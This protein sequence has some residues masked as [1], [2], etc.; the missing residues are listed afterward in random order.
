MK[1]DIDKRKNNNKQK[2]SLAGLVLIFS[3]LATILT[4]VLSYFILR[5]STKKNVLNAKQ[6]LAVEIKED[7][8]HTIKQFPTYE[9]L[10]TYW[11]QNKDT[12]EV[13]YYDSEVTLQKARD[14]AA[15]TGLATDYVTMED[16]AALSEEDCRLYAEIIYN[17]TLQLINLLKNNYQSAYLSIT[18]ASPDYS[19]QTFIISGAS[20]GQNRGSGM[21][22]AFVIGVI[23]DTTK[24]QKKGLQDAV[25]GK[26]SM[27]K[28]GHYLDAYGYVLDIMDGYHVVVDVVYDTS[29]LTRET[30]SQVLSDMFLFVLLQGSLALF[31]YILTYFQSVRP[32]NRIQR[33]VNNYRKNKDSEKVLKS[34][35]KIHLKNEL[36]SLSENI[37]EMIV[38]IDQYLEDIQ[39]ITSEKEKIA[40]ELSVATQIQA[41]MLPSTFPAFPDRKEFDLYATMTPAKDVG[42]DFY[43]FFLVD[44]DHIGLVIA[45]VSGKGIPA[46]LFMVN[47]KTR[48]QNQA[49]LGKSPAEIL[50][51]VN[52]QICAINKS[53]FFVT[54]WI[55]IIDLTTGK[56]L[57]ANAGHEHPVIRHKD[58]SY[59]LVKYKHS[60][61]VGALDSTQ[62][63]EHEFLLKPGDSIF[64][65]TDGVPEATN[66]NKEQ[67]SIGRMLNSLNSHSKDSLRELLPN[68][69]KDIDDFAGD[70]VQ[71]DDITM[72]GFDYYGP[73]G[74]EE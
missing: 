23:M 41:E 45:D 26:N 66:T 53:G 22:D 10:I 18:V 67:F 48:I 74:K 31:L 62:Y 8:V 40:A 7:I 47:S 38:S 2:Y 58:G 44:D 1:K 61:M 64:V 56:G 52:E 39:T 42:G 5:N 21:D 49:M 60:L 27:I 20:P 59:E 69:K 73:A 13:E 71:F 51:A 17:Q 24:E 43:D 19:Q 65:Y 72:L 34:L 12:M 16:L 6:Q 9:W 63:T 46:A 4:G 14:F 29:D 25:A 33:D 30:D 70:A 68:V 3:M 54:V 55:A 50:N 35:G 36:G 57:A 11:Y 28:Y 37:S 15:R 32:I